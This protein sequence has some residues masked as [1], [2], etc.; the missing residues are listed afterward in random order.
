M[1]DQNDTHFLFTSGQTSPHHAHTGYG[2]VEGLY[3]EPQ[4]VIEQLE[5]ACLVLAQ[6]QTQM[7]GSLI[8]THYGVIQWEGQITVADGVEPGGRPNMIIKGHIPPVALLTSIPQSALGW[9]FKRSD[10]NVEAE[11]IILISPDPLL[12]ARWRRT[13]LFRIILIILGPIILYIL[14]LYGRELGRSNW[15]TL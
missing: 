9:S 6:L 2:L 8:L 12:I 1:S 11:P 15:T 13:R 7:S 5:A 10:Y 4:E 14:Y 3:G